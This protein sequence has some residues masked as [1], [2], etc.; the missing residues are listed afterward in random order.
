VEQDIVIDENEEANSSVDETLTD[1]ED[2]YN[3][4]ENRD[5]YCARVNDALEKF[6]TR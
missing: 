3:R 6:L 1:V 5:T 2:N 4:V